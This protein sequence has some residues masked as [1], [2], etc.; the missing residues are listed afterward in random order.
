MLDRTT[1]QSALEELGRRAWARG[2]TIE[3]AIYGGA[4]MLLAF[5]QRR[6]TK[7]VDAVFERDR[8]AVRTLIRE[9]AAEKGWDESWLNDGVKGY[10]SSRDAD[11]RT[12]Y[13][14]YPSEIEPGLRVLLPNQRYLFAMKCLAMRVGGVDSVQDVEDIKLLAEALG[15]RSAETAL[16]IVSDYYPDHKIPPRTRF[17]LEELFP[18]RDR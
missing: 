16:A 5:E 13:R 9:I 8:E 17:G 12:M 1:L 7:D 10:L 3:L 11:S 4:A 14:S 18:P 15:I 2:W 6:A